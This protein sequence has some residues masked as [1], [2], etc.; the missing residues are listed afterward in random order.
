ME[1]TR[2][3]RSMRHRG[4]PPDL[5]AIGRFKRRIPKAGAQHM[6]LAPIRTAHADP[7]PHTKSTPAGP[8]DAPAIFSRA[9]A[10]NRS[11]QKTKCKN[12]KKISKIEK[13]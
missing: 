5:R 8:S 7:H 10:K 12:E 3:Q 1:W 11:S 2:A 4:I 6:I 13:N 9:R